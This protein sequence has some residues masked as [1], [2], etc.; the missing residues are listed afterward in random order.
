MRPL[1]SFKGRG[2]GVAK[3]RFWVIFRQFDQQ[4]RAHLEKITY[5]ITNPAAV[6]LRHQEA[7]INR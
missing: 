7:Q 5:I 2:Y 4:L 1:I 3:I 6:N